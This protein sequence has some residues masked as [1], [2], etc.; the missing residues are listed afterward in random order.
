MKA[1][2]NDILDY[3]QNELS[4]LRKQGADFAKKFPK[5]AARLDLGTDE[6]PDP[7][8]ERLI[9]SFAF[10]TARIQ[11]NIDNEFPELSTSL[12][13]NINPQL[14]NPIPSMSIAHVNV[15]NTDLPA[16]PLKLP[17]HHP[18]AAYTNLG[19]RCR[20]RTCYPI[21]LWP[22]KVDFAGIGST[23][24]YPFL[25]EP[26]EKPILHLRIRRTAKVELNKLDVHKLRFHINSDRLLLNNLYELL[27]CNLKEIIM[28]PDL[29]GH[30]IPS[31][32]K[33]KLKIHPVGFEP[34][35]A[36]LPY[37]ENVNNAYRLIQEYFTFPE[38]F[39]FFDLSQ[40]NLSDCTD[41]FDILFIFDSYFEREINISGENF[42][43]GCS[44]VINLFTKLSEPIRTN[45]YNHEYRI[46]PDSQREH[47]T[48]IHSI[49]SVSPASAQ[50]DIPEFIEPY[51]TFKHHSL[52]NN[53]DVYWYAKRSKT[54]RPG[55]AGTDMF[56]SFVDINFAPKS[57]ELKTLYA[58]LLCTNRHL[59]GSLPQGTWLQSE[60]NYSNLEIS[61]LRKPTQQITAPEGKQLWRLLSSLTLNYLSLNS[62]NESLHALKEI[63]SL[64]NFDDSP[65]NKQQIDGI[66]T[67]KT[68]AAIT[69][70]GSENWRG[71]C[72]GI[73][74]ILDYDLEYYAGNS[75][76]L[77]ASVLN[78][79]F[80]LYAS[81]NS[82]TQLTARKKNEGGRI[83]KTWPPRSGNR[84]IL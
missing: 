78:Y 18:V 66:T 60:E 67:M 82:F 79:F 59:A 4:Y 16:F 73:E 71:F 28:L 1:S 5:I 23:G 62:S 40:I 74:I 14:L 75:A 22:L 39:M 11:K 55:F 80:P 3:Y 34:S 24:E 13:S 15:E 47:I 45:Y 30:S 83:W 70:L 54:T 32:K 61:I 37:P 36:A 51:F 46:N 63:L 27:F 25:Q 48:E 58:K 69:R 50:K 53:N 7:H 44:P 8:I 29:I 31:E 52:E 21:E 41:Y 65:G 35:E 33:R 9:E 6:S 12:L 19:H 49:E 76:F 20:F 77:F 43:L 42:L 68:R 57:I 84:Q 72:R 2:E 64:Y 81:I 17:R 38:K 10:L 56:L 26:Q